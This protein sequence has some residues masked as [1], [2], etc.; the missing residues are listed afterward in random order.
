VIISRVFVLCRLSVNY[1]TTNREK[2]HLQY[3]R[4]QQLGLELKARGYTVSLTQI[5][6]L[7]SYLMKVSL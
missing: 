5:C 4:I 1:Q 7:T 3:H 2:I 6:F